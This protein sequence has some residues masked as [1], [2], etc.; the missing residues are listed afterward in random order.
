MLYCVLSLCIE[1]NAYTQYL[2]QDLETGYPKLAIVK[3]WDIL[4][5]KEGPN[6]LRLQS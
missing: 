2:R 4:F 5:F 1:I 3:F 6:I